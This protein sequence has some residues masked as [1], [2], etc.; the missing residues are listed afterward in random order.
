[1]IVVGDGPERLEIEQLIR[2]NGWSDRVIL[3]GWKAR[4][5]VADLMQE[6]DVLLQPSIRKLGAG[7]VIEAMACGLTCVV[8]DYGGPATS[9]D[10]DRGIKVPVASYDELKESFGTVR[11]HSSGSPSLRPQHDS[12]SRP[13]RVPAS[14]SAAAGKHHPHPF[15]RHTP[16]APL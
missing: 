2:K 7:V 6:S 14:R 5:E 15:G 11:L 16:P 12:G 4:R 1:M 8:T 3:C 10:T 13:K 9:I